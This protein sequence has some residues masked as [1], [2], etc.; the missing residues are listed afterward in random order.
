MSFSFINQ[1]YMTELSWILV[2][3]DLYLAHNN[4][5]GVPLKINGETGVAKK[6]SVRECEKVYLGENKARIKEKFGKK[7]NAL[8][9]NNKLPDLI[10]E[11]FREQI[12]DDEE[13]S[14]RLYNRLAEQYIGSNMFQRY[15]KESPSLCQALRSVLGDGTAYGCGKNKVY[16]LG[17]G[18]TIEVNGHNFGIR[19]SVDIETVLQAHNA[20]VERRL[21][22]HWSGVDNLYTPQEKNLKNLFLS[23]KENNGLIQVSATLPNFC[24]RAHVGDYQFEECITG[25]DMKRLNAN[26][27][28]LMHYPHIMW[29]ESY[30]HPFVWRSDNTICFKGNGRFSKKNI[31]PQQA[32]IIPDS[33][34]GKKELAEKIAYCAATTVL[35]LHSGYAYEVGPVTHLTSLGTHKLDN[36]KKI[37]LD[38]VKIYENRHGKKFS[39]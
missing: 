26:S 11:S 15:F 16:R 23:V 12:R 18:N 24:M 20:I 5:S 9:R 28:V 31:L 39:S 35:N 29:P 22:K 21:S 36:E 34:E 38:G 13:T 2:N 10:R 30:I 37:I 14:E 1:Y 6:F 3:N 33:R 25:F 17:P 8:R 4:G 7:R 27:V 19:K 32:L